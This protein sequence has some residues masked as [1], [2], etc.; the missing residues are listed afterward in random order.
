VPSAAP[1]LPW[2]T[3]AG[4]LW[5]L[6]RT[7]FEVLLRPWRAFAA[8]PAAGWPRAFVFAI[9]LSLV[10]PAILWPLGLTRGPSL[11]LAALGWM[12]FNA[13]LVHLMLWAAGGASQGLG[14]TLRVAGYAQ[15]AIL[16]TLLPR[17]G[18]PAFALWH[19]LV[20]ILGLAQAHRT[21]LVR[22]AAANLV[23]LLLALLLSASGLVPG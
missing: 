16:C 14:A 15:A 22:S 6:P 7:V 8:P 23:P 18:L 19:L 17:V 4:P 11:W 1:P 2:E 5:G 21:Q 12:P 13:A 9:I 20:M 10:P 3:F